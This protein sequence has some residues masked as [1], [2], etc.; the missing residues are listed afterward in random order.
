MQQPP[1][2]GAGAGQIP[3]GQQQFWMM[4]QQ[5]QQQQRQSAPSLV[6]HQ[7]YG[8][9]SQNP[10]SGGEVRSLWI[11]DLQPWMDENYIMNIFGQSGE[12]L[13]AK[14]IRNKLS[15]QSEG[16]GFIEFVSHSVAERV[17]QTYNGA[18]MPSSEQMFKLNWAQVG[19]GEKRQSDG[20]DYTVFV[21]DLAP[22]VT[23]N[24]LCDTFKNVYGSVKGAKV[25]IDRTTGRSK[26]YGFVR[27]GDEHEQMRAMSEMN[28]QY[29][30]T[31]PMRTGPAANKKPLAMQPAMYQ[32]NQ[33]GNPGDNDP[34]NTTIFVGALDASVSDD[35]LK[36]VFG[37]FGELVHVKI[38]PGKR[39]GF[40]QYANRASAEHALS[41]LNGS[42]LGG[43]NIRLS[44]GRSPNKQSQPDQAQWNGSGYY[45]YPPQPQG[46]EPYGYAPQPPQDPNAYY[47]GGYTGYSNYQ[48]QRQ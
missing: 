34:N 17:L 23:D 35:E 15:G 43:Q 3:S 31:R 13:S 33:G 19:A 39:C 29:C 18:L 27:F 14:V 22:E 38:P 28:G 46:Y 4:M 21:G 40:V 36:S 10:G 25:V 45:G 16:Y 5:Q 1:S 24:M 2:N 30:S 12:A 26:G 7:Q 8:A 47:G 41:M 32:T 11:G 42:Q 44:W 9:G 48:Q 20:F 37:Q 6:Q